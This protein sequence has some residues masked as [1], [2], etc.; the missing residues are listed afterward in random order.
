MFSPS[1]FL[2]NRTNIFMNW[3]KIEISDIASYQAGALVK[4]LETKAKYDASQE[5]PLVVAIEHITLRIRSDVKSGGFAVDVDTSKI[6]AELK[7]DAI[8]LIV[9]FAKQRL[10][11]KLSDDERTLANAARTRLDKIAEGKISPS[12]PDNPEPAS[13]T[14]QSSGGA[15]LVRP[16]RNTPKRSD[17]NGL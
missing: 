17:Y 15:S 11:Q 3:V 6:P 5:N 1:V 14:T 12:L 13:A 8:A 9:E 16:A 10:M 2:K 4:A 7:A